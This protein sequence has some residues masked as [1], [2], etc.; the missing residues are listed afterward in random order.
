[1]MIHFMDILP[2]EK[3]ETISQTIAEWILWTD[4][5]KHGILVDKLKALGE[6]FQSNESYTP[7]QEERTFLA[8]M[9]VHACDLSGLILDYD[10]SFKWGIRITQEFHDQY[11]AEEKLDQEK[12]GAPLGFL[13][14][15]TVDNFKKSQ[16][17]FC[18]NIILPMWKVLHDILKFDRVVIDNIENN[19]KLLLENSK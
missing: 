16:A 13:K 15:T 17:G 3:T 8:A 12:F 4:M 18:E 9:V 10:H 1:M 6:K 2:E 14:F 11:N 5:S 19:H 7:S